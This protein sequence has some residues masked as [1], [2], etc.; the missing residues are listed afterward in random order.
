M[1]EGMLERITKKNFRL[2][3]HFGLF[4]FGKTFKFKTLSQRGDQIQKWQ[5]FGLYKQ[6]SSRLQES[7]EKKKNSTFYTNSY[8]RK[9]ITKRE[10]HSR[11]PRKKKYR[12]KYHFRF[13]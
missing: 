9:K 10:L 3:T 5:H 1:D 13:Q 8:G 2:K 7:E 11:N 4:T 12:E 6:W